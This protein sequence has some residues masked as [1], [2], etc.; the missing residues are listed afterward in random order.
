[1]G[2]RRQRLQVF[3]PMMHIPAVCCRPCGSFLMGWESAWGSR[4]RLHA[5]APSELESVVERGLG[6]GT[7]QIGMVGLRRDEFADLD[8][9]S[10]T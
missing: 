8:G 4:P 3:H 7:D 5:V 9:P 1:M 2:L 6:I 10:P